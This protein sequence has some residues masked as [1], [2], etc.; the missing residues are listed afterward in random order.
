MDYEPKCIEVGRMFAVSPKC[1]CPH[2]NPDHLAEDLSTITSVKITAECPDCMNK[3]ENWLCLKCGTV[4]CSRYV[5]EH[6]LYHTLETSHA[7]ALS[8]SDLSFWC[9]QCESYV[10]S[11]VFKDILKAFQDKKF[12]PDVKSIARN[13]EKMTIREE[14]EKVARKEVKIPVPPEII[15]I[16]EPESKFFTE[17]TVEELARKLKKGVYQN[18]VLMVGAGIS[19]SAGIPDFKSPGSG[20]YSILKRKGLSEPNLVFTL[21]YFKSSPELFYEVAKKF[22]GG[23]Y[24][25]TTTHYFIKL[26]EQKNLLSL[27]FTQNIDGLEKKA[28][29]SD[30]KLIQAHGHMESAHCA[31]CSKECSMDIVTPGLKSGTPVYCRCKG[32]IKPDIIFFGESLPIEFLSAS[33]QVKSCDLLII[34]GTSLEV[35]PFASLAGLV[36]KE[37]PRV[38]INR[39]L[40]GGIKMSKGESRDLFLEGDCD[41]TIKYIL[42]ACDWNEDF[43]KLCKEVKEKV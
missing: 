28:G 24:I 10:V 32:P 35:F 3:V 38:L 5:H 17:K 36:K 37:T 15:P 8:F 27:C 11:P 18:I 23:Y 30:S 43:I 1:D 39:E 14:E 40:V 16:E 29:V 42:D 4:K 7:L 2:I 26:L 34:L 6:M 33:Q 13:L 25:P 31:L 12:G 9:Y 20:F 19:V 21:S 22:F 41:R